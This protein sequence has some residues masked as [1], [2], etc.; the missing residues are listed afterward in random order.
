TRRI[1][2]RGPVRQT[3]TISIALGSEPFVF[4]F[5]VS[6]KKVGGFCS[7]ARKKC[8][9]ERPGQ[10][11]EVLRLPQ[12]RRA[13]N[14]LRECIHAP[15]CFLS[16]SVS[17]PHDCFSSSREKW[18]SSQNSEHPAPWELTSPRRSEKNRAREEDFR[19]G[20]LIG[21]SRT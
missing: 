18:C 11:V 12:S 7:R 2:R 1:S 16:W 9:Q 10:P 13:P 19:P 14:P 6:N 3:E 8:I 20:W 5:R 21:R 15:L 17:L 4:C